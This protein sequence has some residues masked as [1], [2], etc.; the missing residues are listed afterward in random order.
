[1]ASL[2]DLHAAQNRGFRELYAS[3]RLVADHYEALAELTGHDVL[4]EA[5][6][7]AQ[8]LLEELRERTGEYGLHGEPAAQRV[9]AVGARAQVAVP[10][11][12]LER[13]QAVRLAV[14]DVQ[15]V[16]TLLT[17]LAAVSETNGTPEL[18]EFCRTWETT[19]LEVEQRVRATAV[20]E[21]AHPDRAVEPLH[22]TAAGRA[23]HKLAV[24]IGA[25][26]EWYDRQSAKRRE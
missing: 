9:G 14:L 25:A 8:R 20:D 2:D 7:D 22:D 11:R 19:M 1:M 18:A 4:R 23:G 21:G 3:A 15:H 26:G 24:W 17:Y 13:N 5:A 10:E 16:V 6:G 12:F